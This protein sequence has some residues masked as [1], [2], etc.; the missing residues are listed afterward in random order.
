MAKVDYIL[1]SLSKLTKKRWEHYVINRIYHKLDDD[2]IEFVCQQCIRKDDTK[3]YLADLFLPQLNLYLEVDEGYHNQD[4]VRLRDAIRRF[5]IAE[6]TGLKEY[7]IPASVVNL[8]DL[9]RNIDDFVRYVKSQKSKALKDGE[10]RKWDYDNRYKA[11]EHRDAGYIEIG[12]H[13][14]FWTHRDALECFGYTKGHYQRA[15]WNVPTHVSSAINLSSKSV[16]WFPKLYED[17]NWMNS[18]SDDGLTVTEINKNPDHSYEEPWDDRIIMARSRDE[19]NRT[20]YRFIGVF[21]VDPQFRTGNEHRFRRV[22][23]RVKTFPLPL[24]A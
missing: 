11:K 22:A 19:L 6:A 2:E 9:N 15:V 23:T 14:A 17:A 4:A 16:V 7:R 13:A 5:D 10:F 20:L 8:T 24:P 21:K 18:L 3:I 12:P 1:R